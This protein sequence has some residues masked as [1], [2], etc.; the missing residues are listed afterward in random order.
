M[1]KLLQILAE[2][3]PFLRQIAKPV[4]DPS[5]PEIKEL[6]EDM[7][8]TMRQANG[9]GL[10]SI[11]V[12]VNCRVIVVDTKDG[13]LGL[14]NPE[15]VKRSKDLELGEE[16]C[17]SVPGKFGMVK[18]SKELTLSAFDSDGQALMFEAKGLFARVIQ[19]EVDHLNGILFIDALEDFTQ[20]Q[21]ERVH[22]AL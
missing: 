10:A 8:F 17:L 4:S 13:P 11:Q 18:R 15:I 2:P 9:I 20:D 19:H 3:H 16:G 12:E 14:I 6:I 5:A 21:R 7:I 22:V 1:P